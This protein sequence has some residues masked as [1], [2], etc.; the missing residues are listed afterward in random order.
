[1]TCVKKRGSQPTRIMN[2]DEKI[3]VAGHNGMVGS[4]IMRG[5]GQSG[6]SNLI[7]AEKKDLD[8]R[9]Q[10]AVRDFFSE[11]RPDYV[12]LSAARVGGIRANDVFPAEFIYDNLMI[13][14]NIIHA[15]YV[16]NVK[17]LL[18]LG[19]TCIYPKMAPQP[20]KEEYLLTGPLEPTNQWYAIAKIAGIK[21]CQAYRKQYNC[22]FISAMPTNLYGPGDNFDLE[23]S[24]VIPALIRK[25]H[26]ARL[27]SDKK[28]NIWGSGKPKREFLYVDDCAAACIMLM[29][30]Y[31]GHDFVNIGVGKDISIME[32]AEMIREITG[33]EGGI[34]KVP[35]TPD[36]T[37]EAVGT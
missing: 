15:A 30:N 35:G 33:Y 36:G 17:K 27:N 2:K 1:M 31:S 20:L 24:H 12:F 37:P 26:E 34:G 14:A 19:S 18:F 9:E 5:L 6:Y 32:L 29:E 22:D 16:H 10:D 8:L 4:A 23:S 25:F 13:E 28:V 3:Y 11:N 21:L 7:M